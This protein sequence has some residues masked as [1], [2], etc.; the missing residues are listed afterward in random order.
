M[1]SSLSYLNAEYNR[2]GGLCTFAADGTKNPCPEAFGALLGTGSVVGLIAILFA[3][4][5]SRILRKVSNRFHPATDKG[6][7]VCLSNPTGVL[8][9]SRLNRAIALPAPDHRLHPSLHRPFAH[10]LGHHQL[11]RRILL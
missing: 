3:F 9:R 4:T 10:E 2:E 11:G 7:S 5:P 6:T 8:T 1:N